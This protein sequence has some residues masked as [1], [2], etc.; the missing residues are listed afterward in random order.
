MLHQ[1]KLF[2][3]AV[4]FFTRIPVPGWVGHSPGQLNQSARFF[5]LIGVL[6][7]LFAALVLWL[8]AQRWPVAVALLISMAASIWMTGAFHEDGLSDYADGMGGGY[9][10]E[11]ILDIMKDSRVGAY[12]VIAL[13]LVL[14]V[15]YQA[16]LALLAR[17]S[18]MQVS[19]ALVAAHTLSRML[20][21]IV[22]RW[23]RYVRED[24][25]ARA[26]PVAQNISWASLSWALSTGLLVLCALY[27]IAFD[28]FNIIS[29]LML[30][31]G[32]LIVLVLQMRKHLG[33]YTGDCLGAVQ[34]LTEA[35]FYLGLLLIWQR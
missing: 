9:T 3:S 30:S 1:L 24:E 32:V 16:L 13:I 8:A 10:R 28:I 7:G 12:G 5:P 26:K 34:Q 17:H 22:M 4:Q 6:V 2:L 14:G 19:M 15:K 25:L 11:K 23:M 21:V 35:G 29:A 20:A 33:G 27:W 18:I 31:I